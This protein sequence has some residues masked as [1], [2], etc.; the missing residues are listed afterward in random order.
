MTPS[1]LCIFA[2]VLLM[3]IGSKTKS[4]KIN[5]LALVLLAVWLIGQS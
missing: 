1:N 3:A 5:G 4:A 2:A